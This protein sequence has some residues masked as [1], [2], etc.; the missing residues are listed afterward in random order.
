[1]ILTTRCSSMLGLMSGA[2]LGLVSRCMAVARPIGSYASGFNRQ[3]RRTLAGTTRQ[4][5]NARTREGRFSNMILILLFVFGALAVATGAFGF[6]FA[7]A[8]LAL[9]ARRAFSLFLTAF[10]VLAVLWVLF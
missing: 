2:S 4:A 1:M 6:F 9:L 5:S 10:V 8:A 7:A 3:A